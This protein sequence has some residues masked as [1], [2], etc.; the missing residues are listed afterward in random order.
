MNDPNSG[1]HDEARFL[2]RILWVS[3]GTIVLFTLLFLVRTRPARVVVTEVTL[4][5]GS[6]LAVRAVSEGTEHSIK[7]PY[8]RQGLLTRT[9]AKFQD[10]Y[11][12][13]GASTVI[14]LTRE[15]DDGT[16]MDFRWFRRCELVRT[17][18]SVVGADQYRRVEERANGSSSSSTDESGFF[19]AIPFGTPS[20]AL[21]LSVLRIEL[22]ALRRDGSS[23]ELRLLDGSNKAVISIPV[24]YPEREVPP[25]TWI[26]ESLPATHSDGDLEVTLTGL[27][28]EPRDE[29]GM[30]LQPQINVVHGGSPSQTWDVRYS[31]SDELGNLSTPWACRLSPREPAW[32]L[33][34][35]LDQR[36]DGRL[37]PEERHRLDLRAISPPGQMQP[38]QSRHDVNGVTVELLGIGG[39]GPCEFQIAG[40]ESRFKTSPWKPGMMVSG[41]SKS[42]SSRVCDV[43]F[44]SGHPFVITRELSNPQ[45]SVRL[46]I[47]N[48][49]GTVL[50]T[51]SEGA[52]DEMRL[53][54]FDPDSETREIEVEMIVQKYRHV[55]F[56]IAPPVGSKSTP[57]AKE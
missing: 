7:I 2:R 52:V 42:C 12:T 10:T 46:V 26:P 19:D 5:G 4:P 41:V 30:I 34:L 50:P 24:P 33:S 56:L 49:E 17:D 47:R 29:G 16:F 14:W 45:M 40:S 36:A 38:W 13:P 57:D 55:E 32:K 25:P 22:P 27:K 20:A 28:V 37:T 31:L 21:A 23:F 35:T 8:R 18:H 39:M 3:C 11:T 6:R 54:F 43:E 51:R 1:R 53:W 44:S 48:Q 9:Q 15:A